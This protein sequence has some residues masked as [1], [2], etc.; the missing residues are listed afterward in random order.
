MLSKCTSSIK[1]QEEMA[2]FV[3]SAQ[4]K[5]FFFFFGDACTKGYQ[6]VCVIFQ[7]LY[8]HLKRERCAFCLFLVVSVKISVRN[9]FLCTQVT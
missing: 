5:H 4:S 7:G 6:D 3:F 8:I 1:N 2:E 9:H